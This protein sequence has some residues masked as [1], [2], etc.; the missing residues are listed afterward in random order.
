MNAVAPTM[1]SSSNVPQPEFACWCP[2]RP[3]EDS[4]AA[5][6]ASDSPFMIRCCQSMFTLTFVVA[7]VAQLVDHEQ[8]HPDVPHQD[9][10]RRLRVLVLEPERLALLGE[11]RRDL[12]EPVDEQVPALRVRRLE[13]V[14]V[15]LDPRPDDHRHAELAGELRA[16]DG[17]LHR[18]VAH[19]RIR[20][21]EPAAAEPRIEV[22]AAGQAVDVVAVPERLAD[23]RRRSARSAPAGSGTRSRRSG[24]RGP[25]PRGERARACP[26]PPI[27]AG[28]RPG[29]SA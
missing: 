4:S 10:H 9:L 29:R 3:R 14:V 24:R 12:P 1:L 8:R 19:G 28:S 26:R 11:R 23:L 20:V 6:S 27:A 25:R 18:L 22:Q 16:G 17:D 5:Y 15:A 13:R 7:A 2:S 21:A